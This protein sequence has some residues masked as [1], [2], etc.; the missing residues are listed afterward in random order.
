MVLHH[1]ALMR[2]SAVISSADVVVASKGLFLQKVDVQE[3][4]IV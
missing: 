1:R 3:A 4:A 2:C